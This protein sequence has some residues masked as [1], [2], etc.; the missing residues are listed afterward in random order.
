MKK[1]SLALLALF[2][3]VAM[4][5]NYT[6]PPAPTPAPPA[7]STQSQTQTGTVTSNPV[8]NSSATSNGGNSESNSSAAATG[9]N[10]GNINS[11]GGNG[12]GGNGT[13]Q[14]G[15]GVGSANVDASTYSATGDV[16]NTLNGG[17][18]KYISLGFPAPVW[19]SVP[20]P[21]GCLVSES[22]A[23][24]VGWNFASGSKSQ[25]FSDVVCTTIRMS[26]AATLHCQ[27]ETAA[28][29]N[30]VAFEKMYGGNG[31]FFLN[32][33]PR[34]LKPMECEDL[35]RPALRATAY[36]NPPQQYTNVVVAS[37]V[38]ACGTPAKRSTG[39]VKKKAA[40]ICK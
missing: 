13:G 33:K 37:P 10:V 20:T 29:L 35:K 19:T 38:G 11:A 5:T 4:A 39:V 9:G 6:P 36:I 2:T 40:P 28:M 22:K 16:S 14:G 26:E 27:F 24:S 34:N 1:A 31:D 15:N 21:F 18:S 25:Q 12:Q 8:S 32:D 17:N 7:T 30:K 23:L 3:G